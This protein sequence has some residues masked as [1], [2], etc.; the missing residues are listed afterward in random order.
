MAVPDDRLLQE[1]LMREY[2]QQVLGPGAPETELMAAVNDPAAERAIFGQPIEGSPPVAP[3]LGMPQMAPESFMDPG[4]ELEAIDRAVGA[5]GLGPIPA[6]PPEGADLDLAYR[7]EPRPHA[8]LAER[9]P[10]GPDAVRRAIEVPEEDPDVDSTQLLAEATYPDLEYDEEGRILVDLDIDEEA[11]KLQNL[12]EV[13][14]APDGTL[15]VGNAKALAAQAEAKVQTPPVAMEL[16]DI[17]G[18]LEAIERAAVAEEPETEPWI[19]ISQNGRPVV[20]F[21]VSA[22]KRYRTMRAQEIGAEV[23]DPLLAAAR[24]SDEARAA[25]TA[26]KTAIGA[27]KVGLST[28]Q[29]IM[30]ATKRYN[31]EIGLRFKRDWEKYPPGY[32]AR[33]PGGK[34]GPTR[35]RL[36]ER[37]FEYAQ[38]RDD[39]RL[40]EQWAD[41]YRK[42]DNISKL[43]EARSNAQRA[44]GM[45]KADTVLGITE[46][47]ALA[48][49]IRQLNGAQQT[50]FEL[51]LFLQS[52]GAWERVKMYMHGFGK[53]KLPDQVRED[54]NTTFSKMGE[55][56]GMKMAT[57][58]LEI[59]NRIQTSPALEHMPPDLRRRYAQDYARAIAGFPVPV[60]GGKKKGKPRPAAAVPPK[61]S[62]EG[63]LPKQAKDA[64]FL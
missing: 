50:N 54:L 12:D 2:G 26:K 5:E 39:I 1:Y 11:A 16:M 21:Q 15:P 22:L 19:T 46:R 18:E 14:R 24:N 35:P 59:A 53:G 29:S 3:A 55:W 38:K 34:G 8:G 63:T 27:Y 17:G 40:M 30:L 43:R 7:G 47:A 45:L 23:F 56:A 32:G 33:V 44:S 42:D 57:S 49:F 13:G 41:D 28:E 61:A 20:R 36:A 62:K 58:G 10:D 9:V 37:R 6:L 60:P 25:L 48:G 31:D 52:F 51:E 4:A 64:G